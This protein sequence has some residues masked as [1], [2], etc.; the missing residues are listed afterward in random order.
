MLTHELVL[1]E[2]NLKILRKM[3]LEYLVK[4]YNLRKKQ[5]CSPSYVDPS[6]H[7]NK[8]TRGQNTEGQ[9]QVVRKDLTAGSGHA[10]ESELFYNLTSSVDFSVLSGFMSA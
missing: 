1:K 8:C 5:T 7:V 2:K 6:T 9:Q 3:D 10:S 4:S